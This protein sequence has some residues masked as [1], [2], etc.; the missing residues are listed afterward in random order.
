MILGGGTPLFKP[1]TRQH[2]KQV[3]VRPSSNAVHVTYERV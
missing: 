2:Y 3:Q 1:G